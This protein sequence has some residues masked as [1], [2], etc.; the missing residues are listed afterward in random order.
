MSITSHEGESRRTG[1]PER[2]LPNTETRMRNPEISEICKTDEFIQKGED[3]LMDA[4][5]DMYMEEK[6]KKTNIDESE[7]Q[8]GG[9][10]PSTEYRKF[11]GDI[12]I[13]TT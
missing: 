4:P 13:H 2:C 11:L 3:I 7:I 5:V 1:S 6:K 10:R 8:G 9:L 12:K